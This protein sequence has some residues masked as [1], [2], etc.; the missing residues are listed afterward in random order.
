ML[1]AVGMGGVKPMHVD[2][3]ALYFD[4]T[5]VSESGERS[6]QTIQ[7]ERRQILEQ[8][9]PAPVLADYDCYAADILMMRRLHRHHWAFR[10]VRFIERCLFKAEKWKKES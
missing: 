2:I 3:D 8:T 6:R 1:K 9:L 10:L 4:M 5:G 7:K